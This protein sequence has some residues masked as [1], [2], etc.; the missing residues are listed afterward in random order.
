MFTSR[1]DE[2]NFDNLSDGARVL[3]AFT[4]TTGAPYR[5]GRL[6]PNLSLPEFERH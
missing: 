2:R 1:A 4:E 3:Q 6:K 5:P